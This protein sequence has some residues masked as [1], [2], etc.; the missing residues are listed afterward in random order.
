MKADNLS[1]VKKKDTLGLCSQ[2]TY[3]FVGKLDNRIRIYRYRLLHITFVILKQANFCC[4]FSITISL[5]PPPP[6]C[7]HHTVLCESFFLWLLP[8]PLPSPTQGCHCALYLC[9]SDHYRSMTQSLRVLLKNS[10]QYL[11]HSVI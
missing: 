7:N 5:L 6:C 3:V 10:Q 9:V 4:I 8:S 11:H 2:K 1:A